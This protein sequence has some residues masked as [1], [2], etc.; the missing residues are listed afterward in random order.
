MNVVARA[1]A[2][3]MLK[4]EQHTPVRDFM[5]EPEEERISWWG[6]GRDGGGS[7]PFWKP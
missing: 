5:L 1:I 3:T 4:P 6:G 2:S 7:H